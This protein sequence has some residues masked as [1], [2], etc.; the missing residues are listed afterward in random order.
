MN[1]QLRD[2]HVLRNAGPDHEAL[3]LEKIAHEPL[4]RENIMYVQLHWKYCS[5]LYYITYFGSQQE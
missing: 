5:M 3:K 4:W 1:G 2:L